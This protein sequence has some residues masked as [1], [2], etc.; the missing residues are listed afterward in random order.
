MD[1]FYEMVTNKLDDSDTSALTLILDTFLPYSMPTDQSD[2][3]KLLYGFMNKN[4]KEHEMYLM[5]DFA[6]FKEEKYNDLIAYKSE[7][8]FYHIKMLRIFM[9][10]LDSSIGNTAKIRLRKYFTLNY[11]L[12]FLI[13]FDDFFRKSDDR[14]D[15]SQMSIGDLEAI[16]DEKQRY[17]LGVTLL[18][19]VISE[20][21]YKIYCYNERNVYRSIVLSMNIVTNLIIRETERLQ[22]LSK[23]YDENYS[24]YISYLLKIF[25]T[26]FENKLN[27]KFD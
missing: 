15:H 18:K 1:F 22:D 5:D 12:R 17:L 11:C 7:P 19:P 20:L 14:D 13:E 21:C 27:N 6:A 16:D 8:F 25:M 24:I 3:L 26:F 9:S 4:T 23:T 10:L 2:N